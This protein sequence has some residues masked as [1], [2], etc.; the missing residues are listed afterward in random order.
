MGQFCFR[1]IWCFARVAQ[2]ERE[3]ASLGVVKAQ[4]LTPLLSS[5]QFRSV[6]M[7]WALTPSRLATNVEF[8]LK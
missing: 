1:I 6:D 5:K 7:S 2:W 8:R 4:R 3:R